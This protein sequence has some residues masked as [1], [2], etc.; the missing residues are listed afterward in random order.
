MKKALPLILILLMI[1]ILASCAQTKGDAAA[2]SGGPEDPGAPAETV[3]ATS[4]EDALG[5]QV[6]I[7]DVMDRVAVTCQGGTTHQISVMGASDKI[8]AQPSMAKFPMLFKIFPQFSNVIDG[9]SF[10]NVNIEELMKAAPDMIFVG[11][12]AEKGN[13]QL[14]EAGFDTF[15]MYIGSADVENQ[16]K[17]F[18]MTGTL[19]GNPERARQLVD[20]YNEKVF[21]VQE[22]VSKVPEAE[23]KA[24]YYVSGGK[25]TSASSGVWGDSLITAAG[26]INV[27][28]EYAAGAKGSEISV[29]Q[30][31]E[32]NPDVIVTQ[33]GN[34]NE[35]LEG[36]LGDARI[37]D[38][39]AMQKHQVHQF[40]IGAFWWD[41]PS[42]EAPLGVMWL[43]K[44]LY[45][46]YTKDIDLEKETKEFYKTFYDYDLSDGDYDSFF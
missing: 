14:V 30:V 8:T 37:T 20:Y 25:I 2:L 16:L 23:Q 42:P 26:G 43:A 19:L 6:A 40:P 17:E 44:T 31:M 24:V 11:I 39:N 22:M 1:L 41:R 29:E 34:G 10:D 45:P 18:M 38:L 3:K 27:T 9:G 7:P 12:T 4:V 32:W 5:R 36:I 21:M 46:E 13:K 33:K 35:N 28:K 15:T